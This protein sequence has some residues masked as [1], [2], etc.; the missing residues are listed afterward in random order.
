MSLPWL[1]GPVGPWILGHTHKDV[2]QDMK[3]SCGWALHTCQIS[4]GSIVSSLNDALQRCYGFIHKLWKKKIKK[5]LL[6]QE[7]S[8]TDIAKRKKKISSKA[9][10]AFIKWTP[11][12]GVFVPKHAVLP[13]KQISNGHCYCYLSFGRRKT[14]TLLVKHYKFQASVSHVPHAPVVLAGYKQD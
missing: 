12:S 1:C 9:L 7:W 11:I 2:S 3:W 13:Q 4:P 5:R 8:K 14:W 6:S 10:H